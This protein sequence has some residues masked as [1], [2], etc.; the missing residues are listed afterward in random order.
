MSEEDKAKIKEAILNAKSL[1]EVEILQQ[2]LQMGKT[3]LFLEFFC[4]MNIQAMY[5]AKKSRKKSIQM[6][7]RRS[8]TMMARKWIKINIRRNFK[9]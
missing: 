8:L 1:E 2:Q 6:R 4:K 3:F 9:V 7:P 5:R